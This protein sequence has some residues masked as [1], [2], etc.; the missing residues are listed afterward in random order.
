MNFHPEL[1]EVASE[2]RQ[3]EQLGF[4]IPELTRNL[5]LQMDKY[6]LCQHQLQLTVDK[7]HTLLDNLNAAEVGSAGPPL[8][9]I[10]LIDTIDSILSLPR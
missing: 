3:M 10:A 9:T 7:Y 1:M 8:V 6:L 4:H 2:C 5:A